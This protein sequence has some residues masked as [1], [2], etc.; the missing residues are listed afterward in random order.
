MAKYSTG[1]IGG[2][3]SGACELCGA[4]G[5]SLQPTTVA[6]AKLEVCE[7]CA[8]HSDEPK[9]A[10]PDAQAEDRKRRKQTAQNIAKLDDARQVETDWE[11]GADYDRDPLPYLL[12][13]YDSRAETARQDAGLQTDELA[14]ELGIN[15]DDILAVEQGRAARAGVGGS[16][17][18]ALESFLDV[19]LAES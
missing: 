9:T 10:S 11:S 6:G 16:V 4:E 1:G 3:A 17:I 12:D 18:E 19:E 14:T 8:R 2:E 7:D 5:T 15:E 13:D